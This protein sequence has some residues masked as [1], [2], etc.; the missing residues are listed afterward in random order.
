MVMGSIQSK[1]TLVTS[2]NT[3]SVATQFHLPELSNIA[4]HR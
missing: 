4:K 2:V 3:L 1:Y